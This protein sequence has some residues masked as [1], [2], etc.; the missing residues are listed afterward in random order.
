MQ[1]QADQP[2]IDQ[3]RTGTACAERGQRGVGEEWDN[4]YRLRGVDVA[5]YKTAQ[6][7][8]PL[9]RRHMC[10][11]LQACLGFNFTIFQGGEALRLARF[12]C[13]REL[14]CGWRSFSFLALALAPSQIIVL[15]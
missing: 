13:A 6:L 1:D 14:R 8:V 4:T 10:R 5:F 11:S 3:I 2:G 9:C 15:I 7:G 12:G